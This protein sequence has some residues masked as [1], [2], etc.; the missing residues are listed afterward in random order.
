MSTESSGIKVGAGALVS[1][2]LSWSIYGGLR[3][4][5]THS[6]SSAKGVLINRCAESTVAAN[7]SALSEQVVGIIVGLGEP[8]RQATGGMGLDVVEYLGDEFLCDV[9]DDGEAGHRT[10]GTV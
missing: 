1:K 6:P 10:E 4:L 5:F 3:W 8:W 7:V 9:C 2:D